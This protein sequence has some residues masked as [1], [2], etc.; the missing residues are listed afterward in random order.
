MKS[1]LIKRWYST[2]NLQ[3]L[4]TFVAVIT[5]SPF[6]CADA[7]AT[8]L[9]LIVCELQGLEEAS[10]RYCVGAYAIS[11]TRPLLINAS[12]KKNYTLSQL[13]A[14]ANYTQIWGS[15]AHGALELGCHKLDRA[16][17]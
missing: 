7:F 16:I 13:S 1:E 12:L 6:L 9:L 8:S 10:H 14:L 15:D 4:N 3:N 11:V 17:S 2:L 5:F